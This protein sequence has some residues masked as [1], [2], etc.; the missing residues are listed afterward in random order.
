MR[1]T[2]NGEQG[3]E[4]SNGKS[5]L[6]EKIPSVSQHC[7]QQLDFACG[8]LG[9]GNV[10]EA[11][12]ALGNVPDEEKGHPDVL[13]ASWSILAANDCWAEAYQVANKHL[14]SW[15][16]MDLRAWINRSYAIRRMPEGDISG[17]Y[18]ALLPA[19]QRFPTEFLVPYNLACYECQLGHHGEALVWI[20]RAVEQGGLKRILSLAEG[21]IDL[22]PILSSIR[23]ISV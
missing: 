3:R 17:A 23:E 18:Q 5:I 15:G 21:D 16:E 1:F 8:W 20:R 11:A 22:V 19:H 13:S 9:L 14:S 7:Q 10:E 4:A 12:A 6:S 2:G